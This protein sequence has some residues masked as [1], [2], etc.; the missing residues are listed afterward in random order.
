MSF[1]GAEFSLVN[2]EICVV[3]SGETYSTKKGLITKQFTQF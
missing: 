3:T 1:R 2:T